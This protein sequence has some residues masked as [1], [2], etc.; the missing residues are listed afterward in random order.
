M[1]RT[2]RFYQIDQLLLSGGS[3][4]IERFLEVLSISR[5]TFK[6]DLAYLRDRLNAPIE[7][8]PFERGYRYTRV[9]NGPAFALPGLWFNASEARALL[10]MQHLL[11]DLQPGLLGAQIEPLRARLRAVLGSADHSAEEVERRVRLIPATRR[12]LHPPFF[13]AIASATLRR[14]RI[15]ITHYARATDSLTEREVSPQQLVFY[16]ENWYLVAWCHLRRGLRSFAVDALRAVQSLETLAREVAAA[17]V[18]A[19]LARGYGIFAGQTVEWATLR[20][21]PA[22]ARWVSAE[23]WHPAQRGEFDEAGCWRLTLPYTDSRELLMDVLRHGP[24]VEV[25]APESL[26]AQ[27]VEA[28][29]QSLQRYRPDSPSSRTRH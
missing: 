28:L 4:S 25:L 8:D 13:E 24:E 20:F 9:V 26:R 22:R 5:A 16:A 6:R 12:A 11:A 27:A 2:E 1:D 15:R 10:M 3:V 18:E 17:T 23:I 19:E 7:W 29:Q 21:Q 14:R